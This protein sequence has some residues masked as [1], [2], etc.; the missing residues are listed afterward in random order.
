MWH[1]VHPIGPREIGREHL[2]DRHGED[3]DAR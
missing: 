2:R 1:A 3:D